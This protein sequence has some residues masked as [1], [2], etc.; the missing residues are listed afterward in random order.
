MKYQAILGFLLFGFFF[1]QGTYA[2]ERYVSIHNPK[3]NATITGSIV[4]HL[5][6]EPSSSTGY[7]ECSLRKP[8]P[9]R[10]IFFFTGSEILPMA[11]GT[12]FPLDMSDVRFTKWTYFLSCSIEDPSEQVEPTETVVKFRYLPPPPVIYFARDAGNLIRNPEFVVLRGELPAFWRYGS[13]GRNNIT[14]DHP[15]FGL[16]SKKSLRTTI[17]NHISWDA[18][19]YFQDISALGGRTYIYAQK[20]HTTTPAKIT[21]RYIM[22]DGSYQYDELKYLPIT[23]GTYDEA[24]VYFITPKDTVALTVWTSIDSPGTLIIDDPLLLLSPIPD[25]P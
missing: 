22:K 3:P 13:Y 24:R 5:N 6:F 2:T 20:Y 21:V 19:W 17:L 15:N 1:A 14:Q 9:A 10:K 11:T 8:V 25:T 7:L 18:K 16:I 4:V 23:T 12:T